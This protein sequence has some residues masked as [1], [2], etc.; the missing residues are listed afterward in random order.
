MFLVSVGW[1]RGGQGR[2]LTVW[3]PPKSPQMSDAGVETRPPSP[4]RESRS[5]PTGSRRLWMKVQS[6]SQPINMHV[7]F[8]FVLPVG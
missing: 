1:R 5:S 2:P 7:V 3:M 6:Y 4:A 8:L